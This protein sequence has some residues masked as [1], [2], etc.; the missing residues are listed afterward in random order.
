MIATTHFKVRGRDFYDFSTKSEALIYALIR[1]Y[2]DAKLTFYM[3]THNIAL[4][5][6][7]DDR[8][9][10]RAIKKLESQGLIICERSAARRIIR[11]PLAN[12]KNKENLQDLFN[13]VYDKS[14]K[15]S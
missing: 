1:S 7:C 12:E 4:T 10:Q 15:N 5:I 2:W 9:V 14:K 8:T 3:S 6:N 13:L 11:Q